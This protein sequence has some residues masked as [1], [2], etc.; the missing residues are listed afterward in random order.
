L[1]VSPIVN[2]C[3][4]VVAMVAAEEKVRL[5]AEVAL[6]VAEKIWN[7]AE[8]VAVPPILRSSVMFKGETTPRILCQLEEVLVAQ[9]GIPLETVK[10]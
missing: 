8:E 5:P 6:P 9:A 7:L 1:G 10:T 3:L 4:A 2:D